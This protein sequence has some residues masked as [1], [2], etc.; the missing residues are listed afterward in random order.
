MY[1]TLYMC[2]DER[3]SVAPDPTKTHAV[4][5]SY[6]V[7]G[8]RISHSGRKLYDRELRGVR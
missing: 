7:I 6:L 1:V 2:T 3:A 4:C 8:K 5:Y